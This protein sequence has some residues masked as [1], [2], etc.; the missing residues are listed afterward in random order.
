MFGLYR[1]HGRGPTKIEKRNV[2]TNTI[3]LETNL[4]INANDEAYSVFFLFN[5]L[6]DWII[7]INK[8]SLYSVTGDISMLIQVCQTSVRLSCMIRTVIFM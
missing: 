4:L 3:D 8:S 6:L 2:L 7:N 1:V 5:L